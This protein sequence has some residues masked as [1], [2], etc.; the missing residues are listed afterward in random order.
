M[1]ILEF[2]DKHPNGIEDIMWGLFFILVLIVS[3]WS[4]K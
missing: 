4:S 3:G 2:I 1:T